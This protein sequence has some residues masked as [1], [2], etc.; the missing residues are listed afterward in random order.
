M[1]LPLAAAAAF[2][3][4]GFGG[5]WLGD[6]L[7]NL[8]RTYSWAQ[9]GT[10]WQDTARQFATP[11]TGGGSFIRPMVIASFSFDYTISG[12]S[13]PGWYAF[14]FAVHLANVALV[15]FIVLRLARMLGA[16]GAIA[17]ALAAAFFGVAPLPAEGVYWLSARGDACVTLCSL[18]AIALW[19]AAGSAR[20]RARRSFHVLEVSLSRNRRGAAG[21]VAE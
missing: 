8:H 2:Y 1:L 16:G 14:N 6:D 5:F 12:A 20:Q 18:G 11:I 19:T 21:A 13:Y 4:H 9:A 17:A 3:A 10:L 15:A 7:P